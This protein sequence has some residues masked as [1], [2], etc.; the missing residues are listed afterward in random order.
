M[1]KSNFL[2]EIIDYFN[3]HVKT[4]E[5][6]S[7]SYHLYKKDQLITKVSYS[8]KKA[9]VF[10]NLAPGNYRI[11]VYKRDMEIVSSLTSQTLAIRNVS[12]TNIINEKNFI[13]D[14]PNYDLA[15]I[16]ELLKDNLN[17]KSYLSLYDNQNNYLNLSP[18]SL[19]DLESETEILTCDS[20]NRY[21]KNYHYI[22]L[23]HNSD[24]ILN[25]FLSRKS[26]VDLQFISKALYQQGYEKGAHYIWMYM[27]KNSGCSIS[28]KT[29]IGKNFKL[30]LGGINTIIHPNAVIG[31]NVKIAQQVTIGFSGSSKYD[32]PIIGNNVYIA[33][34]AMCL[35]GKI[36]S[37]VVIASNAVVLIE[38]PDNCV[39][40]GVPAKIISRD[41]DKYKRLLK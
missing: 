14:S 10:K 41:M 6:G 20:K 7:F 8:N 1:D 18:V 27:R 40:A 30:G 38:V 33:P 22:S 19:N 13:L 12:Q 28:Y 25:E 32:G 17:I 5:K 29:S 11:K 4:N 31:D 21:D 2:F 39:V 36:G 24:N 26:I 23:S 16:Y 34:G 37:N 3:I 9:H 15:W 35:G